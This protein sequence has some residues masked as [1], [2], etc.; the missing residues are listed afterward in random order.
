L[1]SMDDRETV[2]A[3]L[4]AGAMG[5][6]PKTSSSA[7]LVGALRLIM[8]KGIYLPP[9]AFLHEAVE[10]P[11]APEPPRPR[12]AP[13]A[14]TNGDAAGVRPADLGLTPRQADVLYQ[15]LQGAR[16]S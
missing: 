7:I 9:S 4:D 11:P 1:S 12:P 2:L 10:R 16:P 3:A 5:F 13:A 6:I 14:E 15:I 8:A